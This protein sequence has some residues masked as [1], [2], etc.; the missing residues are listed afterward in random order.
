MLVSGTTEYD[1]ITQVAHHTTYRTFAVDGTPAAP[2]SEVR[3]R[4][5]FPAEL[6][7]ALTAARFEVVGRYADFWE[8][9]LHADATQL[10][11]VAR[12]PERTRRS[13]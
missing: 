9:P 8:T 10:V 2:A 6:D 11:V 12:K 5:H 4:Q 1:P 3:V 13:A 7:A